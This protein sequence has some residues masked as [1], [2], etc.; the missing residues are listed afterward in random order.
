[1]K[2]V[3]ATAA[4]LALV[5]ALTICYAFAKSEAQPAY[6]AGDTVYVCGCGAGCDCGTVSSKEGTCVCG[7]ALI[8]TKITKVEKGKLYYMVNGME[9]SAPAT[10]KYA[11][12]CGAGCP[13]KTISQK[14][15]KCACGQVMEKVK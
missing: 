2:N 6:K 4:A 5:L 11:C 3:V 15:G 10:G 9:M 13:C 7:K 14:P 12:S 8:K 1:M